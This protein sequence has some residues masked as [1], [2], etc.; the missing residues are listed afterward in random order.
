MISHRIVA[1]DYIIIPQAYYPTN[2]YE[3]AFKYVPSWVFWCKKHSPFIEFIFFRIIFFFVFCAKEINVESHMYK[4]TNYDRM[5][6]R[7]F[8]LRPHC[9]PVTSVNVALKCYEETKWLVITVILQST[10]LHMHINVSYV[11]L[12]FWKL[13]S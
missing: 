9:E 13:T 7:S 8:S 10:Y 1:P 3:I 5:Y 6:F 11:I 12:K 4:V 2:L